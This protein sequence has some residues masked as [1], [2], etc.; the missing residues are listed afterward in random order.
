MDT[1]VPLIIGF[2]GVIIGS[3]IPIIS[4]LIQLRTSVRRDNIKLACELGLSDHRQAFEHAENKLVGDSRKSHIPY[5]VSF[6]IY[7]H[8]KMLEAADE[9]KLNEMMVLN[10]ARRNYEF[11][12][13][14]EKLT[15]VKDDGEL[16][17]WTRS[18]KRKG[19]HNQKWN[20]MKKYF[21][22][23]FWGSMACLVVIAYKFSQWIHV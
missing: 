12:Q 13:I 5:P 22:I 7:S 16:T 23:V 18:K 2:V 17:R 8:L 9:K 20:R 14:L 15:E 3:T 19:N 6:Y 10:I 11:G 4:L 1:W 21:P